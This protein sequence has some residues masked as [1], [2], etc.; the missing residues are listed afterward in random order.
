MNTFR[1]IIA[2]VL[3]FI[4]LFAFVNPGINV[5][6]LEKPK[7]VIS[8]QADKESYKFNDTAHLTVT[9]KNIS[10]NSIGGTAISLSSDDLVLKNNKSMQTEIGE[11]K[12]NEIKSVS[13]DVAI[14]RKAD[15][16]NFIERIFIFFA[17]LFS[18]TYDFDAYAENP[19][20]INEHSRFC[21]AFGNANAELGVDVWYSSFSQLELNEMKLVEK[22][23]SESENIYDSLNNL[24]ENGL[25]G[26]F[27]KSLGI[28]W[29][30][31]LNGVQGGI[32][33][34]EFSDCREDI[35]ESERP[36]QMFVD[37]KTMR[38]FD[39]CG[40]SKALVLYSFNYP[41]DD[42]TYRRFFYDG[43]D[44][45]SC[46]NIWG[47]KQMYTHIDDAVTVSDIKNIKPSYDVVCFCGHGAI[48][49]NSPVMC[50]TEKVTD[51]NRNIYADDLLNGRIAV[52]Q[53]DG[54]SYYW[55]FPSL[56][57][58][59]YGKNGLDDKIIFMQCCNA[60]G[61]DKKEDYS[62]AQA[63]TGAG[64]D[65]VVGFRNEVNSGY[66]RSFMKTFVESYASGS[67]AGESFGKASEIDPSLF[68]GN[69]GI[70]VLRGYS[71][72]RLDDFSTVNV[73]VINRSGKISGSYD[74]KFRSG[75]KIDLQ[76]I[77]S[78]LSA[79]Y[80]VNADITENI[81]TTSLK[82]E[83]YEVTALL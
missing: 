69:N 71:E 64:A 29:F 47:K 79:L 11:M 26:S 23:L 10:E 80:G 61:N 1:K 31:Y 62:F 24:K 9:V 57:E 70:P 40:I 63:F 20:A 81:N 14:S 13:V 82:G 39:D 52:V 38:K 33:S 68:S 76:R 18:K 12:P 58:N 77:E 53:Y 32:A 4:L 8:I 34:E 45:S 66:C 67:P 48:Y 59:S 5:S 41:S 83:K 19:H 16:L 37:E 44:D 75:E 15:G 56:F 43:N 49:R 36:S 30:T 46:V 51:E 73:K 42:Q 28:Y 74:V 21:L 55:V 7:F 25:I 27:T 50:L 78:A 22:N 3:C 2:G 17:R 65:A 35:D 72:S 54:Y 6:A 60:F